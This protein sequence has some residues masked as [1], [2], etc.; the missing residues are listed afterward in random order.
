MNLIRK[1]YDKLR[2]KPLL[3]IP[4]VS[5]CALIEVWDADLDGLQ[6]KWVNE[7]MN[8]GYEI[9]EPVEVKWNFR[10]MQ[11]EYR[12]VVKKHCC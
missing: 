10:T 1:I 5:N 11:I 9:E 7:Y 3:V 2:R 4:V 12:F 8:N 6:K